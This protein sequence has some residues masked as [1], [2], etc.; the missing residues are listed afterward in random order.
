MRPSRICGLRGNCHWSRTSCET[1]CTPFL[2]RGNNR[3]GGRLCYRWTYWRFYCILHYWLAVVAV[4]C[5]HRCWNCHFCR[6]VLPSRDVRTLFVGEEGNGAQKSQSRDRVS[7]YLHKVKQDLKVAAHTL[8]G[9]PGEDAIYLTH[10]CLYGFL[11]VPVR[12]C[13]TKR[14]VF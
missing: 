7:Y 10:S 2:H 5:C 6:H 12:V 8:A 11:P 14:N 1:N 13:M 4:D 3:T 9:T